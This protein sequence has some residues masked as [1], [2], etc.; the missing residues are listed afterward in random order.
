MCEFITNIG[1]AAILIPIIGKI[2]LEL[3]Q[4]PLFYM[5]PLTSKFI[6]I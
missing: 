2:S 6:L 1:V 4:N 3:G 5:L